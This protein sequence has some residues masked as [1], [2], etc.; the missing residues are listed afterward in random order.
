MIFRQTGALTTERC[1]DP[2][3]PGLVRRR[4]SY[5][6]RTAAKSQTDGSHIT[7]G[8]CPITSMMMLWKIHRKGK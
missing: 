5:R 6:L 7:L 8:E 4:N 3:F 2:D 1:V